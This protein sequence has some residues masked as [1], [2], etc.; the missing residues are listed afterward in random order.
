ML[1][2]ISN[3]GDQMPAQIQKQP[4]GV[5]E[6]LTPVQ[7]AKAE[8]YYTSKGIGLTAKERYEHFRDD[9]EL[10][11]SIYYNIN[12]SRKSEGDTSRLALLEWTLFR[13]DGS[14]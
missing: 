5:N 6:M 7:R 1:S 2:R 10:S 11:D 9:P 3:K 4:N 12:Y 13:W 14:L 8:E